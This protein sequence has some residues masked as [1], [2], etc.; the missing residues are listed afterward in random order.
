MTKAGLTYYLKDPRKL[1]AFLSK[2]GL[3]D[4]MPDKQ[5]LKMTYRIK[6]GVKLNLDAPETFNEKI[7][8]LK[9]YDRKPLYTT[10]VDKYE[11]K[12]YVAGIIGQE[13]II[14]TLGVWDH[15]DDID[16]SNLPDQFVLKCTHDSGG[17]VICRDKN[18]LDREK[19]RRKLERSLE[20]NY[21][22]LSREW[23]YKNVR[24]R[25]LAEA[26]MED[27]AVQAD[28]DGK[29]NL[30]D[31]KFFCFN[32]EPKLLY[33]STGLEN[34][35]TAKISFYDLDGKEMPFHRKDYAPYHDAAIPAN[36]GELRDAASKIAAEVGSPF[37]RVDL[38]SIN[39]MVY[40]SEITFS[41]C[42]GNIPFDPESADGEL[43]KW[44]KIDN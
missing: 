9:V 8:W 3:L 42:G 43:G 34:H 11:A 4:W 31:Y 24:R 20:N 40:F 18:S 33:I 17:V 36:F 25:I 12:A 7:Q 44:L 15:F 10:M 2:R 22:R 21:Y 30:T 35:S 1:Y 5:Y 38:Y 41:P 37:V 16:F 14:P 27:N 23:P 6:H 28:S 19:A 29:K 13:H 32:G 39:G 26:Y